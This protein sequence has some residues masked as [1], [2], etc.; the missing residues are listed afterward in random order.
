[1]S[2]A[3]SLRIE[4]QQAP[5]PED[6]IPAAIAASVP[7]PTR[8]N[9]HTAMAN[10]TPPAATD[11]SV[12][13][14]WSLRELGRQAARQGAELGWTIADEVRRS[15]VLADTVQGRFARE[16]AQGLAVGD[17][18]REDMERLKRDFEKPGLDIA[19]LLESE[20]VAGIE[21]RRRIAESLA[22]P[23]DVLARVQEVVDNMAKLSNEAKRLT[24]SL[25]PDD[26][27]GRLREFEAQNREY[28]GRVAN[29]ASKLS[30][31]LAQQML[32]QG[33]LERIREAQDEAKAFGEGFVD[34]LFPKS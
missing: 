4:K 15:Q 24:R 19:E 8:F 27:L 7:A 6:S 20:R 18:Y 5:S 1:M 25:V 32:D 2:Y 11:G 33:V 12:R 9:L 13:K 22:P 34:G 23:P 28:A 29:E 30:R 31:D 10:A 14:P 3:A 17:R 16:I 26:A 21:N